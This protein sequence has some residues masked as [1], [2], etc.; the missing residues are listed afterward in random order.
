VSWIKL[1]AL[2]RK[3]AVGVKKLA[4]VSI[5]LGSLLEVKFIVILV[6]VR[7]D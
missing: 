6:V 5:N 3:K 1:P 7:F 2:E 4:A